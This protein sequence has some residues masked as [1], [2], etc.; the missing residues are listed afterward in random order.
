MYLLFG[1]DILIFRPP[2]VFRRFKRRSCIFKLTNWISIGVDMQQCPSTSL[3]EA[4]ACR[5]FGLLW[6]WDV[7][8]LNLREVYVSYPYNIMLVLLSFP[9][10]IVNILML[11]DHSGIMFRNFGRVVTIVVSCSV[12][13]TRIYHPESKKPRTVF[14]LLFSLL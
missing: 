3:F 2:W 12:T 5:L 7:V 10:N 14:S 4:M 11:C 9:S 8:I 6:R 1:D 13:Q